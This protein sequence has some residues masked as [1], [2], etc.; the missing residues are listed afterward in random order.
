MWRRIYCSF[1]DA[2]RAREAVADLE[3]LGVKRDQIHTVA[4]TDIDIVGLPVASKAVL[5]D[6]VWFWDRAI[7]YGSL[8]LFGVALTGAILALVAESLTWTLV[9]LLF[10]TASYRFGEH[11]AVRVPH[12]HLAGMRVPLQHGEVVLMIDVPRGRVRKVE[13]QVS[14]KHPETAVG[15]VGWTINS[16]GI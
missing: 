2:S 1:P 14:G 4:S 7:W 8:A 12:F 13:Q 5:D 6:R 9:A 16:A 10:A 15:G 3:A 11:F